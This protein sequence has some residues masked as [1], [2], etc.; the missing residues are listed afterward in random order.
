MST[1]MSDDPPKG[2]TAEDQARVAIAR[3]I[4]VAIQPAIEQDQALPI[5]ALTNDTEPGL[6]LSVVIVPGANT[7]EGL[8]VQAVAVPWFEIMALI[9]RDPNALDQMDWRKFEE[10][11]AGAWSAWSKPL[12]GEVILT[13]R[14]GDGGRDVIVTLPGAASVRLFDQVKRYRP[15]QLVA[16]ET[17]DAM[18]G[19]LQKH[20]NVSKGF[21]TTTS[22]FAP[23]VWKDETLR[24]LMPHRLELKPRDALL[25]WLDD[26]AAGRIALK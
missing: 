6:L 24:R 26:V 4:R 25:K 2:M 18:V 12:N 16:A 14:K 20:G 15:G 22:D 3:N 11:V 7:D 23:G 19:V 17:V 8:L 10:L 21:I 5:R 9:Q 1:T 13:P